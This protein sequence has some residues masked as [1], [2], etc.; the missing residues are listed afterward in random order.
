[1]DEY[2]YLYGALFSWTVPAGS[3]VNS[4]LVRCGDSQEGNPRSVV[5]VVVVIII[6]VVVIIVVVGVG[7][8]EVVVVVLCIVI[9]M[10][11]FEVI[12]ST[13]GTPHC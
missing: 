2:G 12:S 11:S 7:V 1:V 3:F 6:L 10:C 9:S 4:G 13:V 8:G 5:V